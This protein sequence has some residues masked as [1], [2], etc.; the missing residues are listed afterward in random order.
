MAA[1]PRQRQQ[2]AAAFIGWSEQARRIM[3]Q[4]ATLRDQYNDLSIGTSLTDADLNALADTAGITAADVNAA[5]A[6]AGQMVGEF[7]AA[8]RAAFNK[9]GH[10]AP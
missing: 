4:G 6:L 8:R 10:G 3:E 7:T 2:F 1:T 9:I 5:L